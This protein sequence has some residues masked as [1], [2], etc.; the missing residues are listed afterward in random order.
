MSLLS[1]WLVL[2]IKG[3]WYGDRTASF[4]YKGSA[5]F[6]VAAP[7]MLYGLSNLSN[8]DGRL[9]LIAGL[10]GMLLFVKLELGSEYPML[11]L[12]LFRS[13]REFTCSNLASML[14]YGATYA[15][16]FLMSLY[17]QLV[18]GLDAPKAGMI[19]LV[20][21]LVM[22]VVAP[23]AG[24]ISDHIRPGKVASAGMAV[25]ALGL[26]FLSMLDGSISIYVIIALL[27]WIGFGSGLFSSP[28]NNAIMG[29]V[30]K[31]Y[32]GTATSVLSTMRI[33][34]QATSMAVVTFIMDVNQVR[35]ATGLDNIELLNAVKISFGVF[36][37]LCLT[38]VAMSL[39]RNRGNAETSL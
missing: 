30:D 5:C 32:Y 2:K 11:N 15:V 20:Q 24:S 35:V 36:A 6:M 18:C 31:K 37:V 29:S 38:G 12:N 33:F 1:L 26:I 21:S 8:Q 10:I 27:M 9:M 16:S 7:L 22:A 25:N 28:N 17:L 3:E 14:H 4:D 19:I 39:A 23:R 34:G 13:N